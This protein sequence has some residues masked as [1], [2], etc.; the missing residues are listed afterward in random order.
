MALYGFFLQ[1]KINF[2]DNFSIKDK[3]VIKKKYKENLY[4]GSLLNNMPNDKFFYKKNGVN[5]FFD[6][7]NLSDD[8]NVPHD[9]WEAYQKKGINFVAELT[10]VFSGF[11][12]DENLQK[13]YVFNDHLT[14][15]NIYYY[16]TEKGLAFASSLQ[17]LTLLF[18]QNNINYTL[19][20]DAVY[21]MAMY[22][23]VMDNQ[24]YINEVKQLP[25]ASVLTY[26]LIDNR[27]SVKSYFAYHSYTEK[28]SYNEAVEQIEKKLTT[29]IKNN[30]QKNSEYGNKYFT[31]LSG[32]MDARVN[33]MIAKKMGFKN[34]YSLT[35]GQAS[36]KDLRYAESIARHENFKH[37]SIYL[38]GGD[39]LINDIYQNYIKPTD[40]MIYYNTIAHLRYSLQQAF[41]NEYPMIH[42]GQIGDLIFGA[43]TS[44][45]FD[46]YKNKDKLGYTGFV[47]NPHLLQKI[48]SLPAILKKYQ[49][50]G[51]EMFIY[52]ERAMHATLFGD[53]AISDFAE[54]ISP[55]YDRDLIQFC[56]SL[57][58]E[59]K[60]NQMIYFDWL[61]KYHPQVLQYPWDKIE[62]KPNRKW[63]IKYG[64]IFKRYYN[65]A[66]KYFHWQYD[67][68]NPYGIWL[69]QNKKILAELDKII[70]REISNDLLP[71]EIK[72]D[73]QQIYNDN[74]FEYRNKFAVVTALLAVKLHFEK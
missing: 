45:D 13:I 64:K 1:G 41:L 51:Y 70:T 46:F 73:L 32:G 43:F 2:E 42:S 49:Y 36:S 31:L 5:I 48:K 55:F 35:F 9:F 26:D 40:G 74:I 6:G 12:F 18:N 52:E 14:T 23:F 16:H 34:I 57:P 11:I 8:L 30:W 33:A 24:T 22:G 44:T 3:L 54:T 59:Y 28:I 50:K 21:M 62:M 56:I 58:K 37:Q 65:G 67:S 72:S 71:P 60:K 61:R 19:N 29:S 47:K 15:K 4:G 17:I 68:M 39:Y 53:K 69:K 7:I 63:K 20:H 10:G 27:I 38:D 25:Y 66:K